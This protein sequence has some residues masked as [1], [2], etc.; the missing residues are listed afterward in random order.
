MFIQLHGRRLHY[1]MNNC[2]SADPERTVVF[3]HGLGQNLHAWDPII[4][5]LKHYRVVRYDIGGHG[6]SDAPETGYH[7]L[8]TFSDELLALLNYLNIRKA[9]L[10]GYE[11]GA[12]IA[13]H[14]SG[15]YPDYA[16]R[17]ITASHP[18]YYPDEIRKK[19]FKQRLQDLKR[20][21]MSKFAMR[22]LHDI[23]L[24][25]DAAYLADAYSQVSIETYEAII[26]MLNNSSLHHDHSLVA[27]PV[28]HLIGERDTIYPP[29]MVLQA[30]RYFYPA[31]ILMMV[32][33]AKSLVHVDNPEYTAQ[34]IDAFIRTEMNPS[35]S[36]AREA[37][38]YYNTYT[39]L[40]HKPKQPSK[41]HHQLRVDVMHQF[42]ARVNGHLLQGNW[43][44]RK[45]QELIIY[46][47]YN[48]VAMREKLYDLFWPHLN[49]ENAQ[50]MLRVSV[51][52]LK[53]LIDK[54]YGTSFVVSSRDRIELTGEVESD[55]LETLSEIKK[56]HSCE[57]I[58]EKE[59]IA[60]RIGHTFTP[61]I[62]EGYYNDWIMD[63]REELI[64]S[65][66]PIIK[67]VAQRYEAR[68]QLLDSILFYKLMLQM[69]PEEIE[70]NQKIASLY[71]D[72]QLK[73]LAREWH[74]RYR[75]AQYG[76][77]DYT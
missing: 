11:L 26:R 54:P 29:E 10:F 45:A 36:L 77:D 59:L 2:D 27:Q 18:V 24:H 64:N 47:I 25:A 35:A 3:I 62:L 55:L 9:I 68:N 1:E 69:L 44:V 40:L 4:P 19:K 71:D 50:N 43:K 51:N 16:S 12:C 70:L 20:N 75:R 56:F 42:E 15:Q 39:S 63:L 65:A 17:L 67:W 31:P 13:T 32:P 6:E 72:L 7:H 23:T 60:R 37:S 34:R 53:K 76:D 5:Y 38:T 22:H 41:V 33:N 61:S 28:L 14:F 57:N 73:G 8:H 21:G 58:E 46:L 49:L 30:I 74:E 48:K 66:A 52:H